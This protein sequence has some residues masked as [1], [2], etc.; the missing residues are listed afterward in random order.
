MIP[1]GCFKDA[2]IPQRRFAADS[3]GE[4][5]SAPVGLSPRGPAALAVS[6]GREGVH[7]EEHAAPSVRQSGR[8]LSRSQR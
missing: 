6:S 2:P 3:L 4:P 8:P 7:A 1:Q 5:S